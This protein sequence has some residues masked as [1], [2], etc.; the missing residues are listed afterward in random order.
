MRL[1]LRFELDASV[2]QPKGEATIDLSF[3]AKQGRAVVK[4]QNIQIN[5]GSSVLDVG[6]R[7]LSG[8]LRVLLAKQLSEAIN[9]AITDLPQ[10]EPLLKKVEILEI[11]D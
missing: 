5:S 11:E 3:S 9:Q 6:S 4:V 2:V 1:H 7:V 8:P 10:Q